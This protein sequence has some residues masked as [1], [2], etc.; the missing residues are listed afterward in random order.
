MK[1]VGA[2]GDGDALLLFEDVLL[3]VVRCGCEGKGEEAFS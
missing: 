3:G 1:L 2:L